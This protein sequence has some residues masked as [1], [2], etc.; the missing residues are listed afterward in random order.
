MFHVFLALPVLAVFGAAA[1]MVLA[2]MLALWGAAFG[3]A[4]LA[5]TGIGLFPDSRDAVKRCLRIDREL[6]PDPERAAQYAELFRTYREIHD[7]LAPVYR[8]RG[9]ASRTR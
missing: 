8:K 2:A 5:G 9:T 1:A 6:R 4:L 7:A 3:A